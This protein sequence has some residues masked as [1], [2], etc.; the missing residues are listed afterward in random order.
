MIPILAVALALVLTSQT[1]LGQRPRDPVDR[2]DAYVE[3]AMADWGVPGLSIAIVRGDSL[4][5]ARGY[6]VRRTGSPERVDAQ[7][8][9]AIGSNSKAFTT[10]A[11][12]MLAEE[13]KLGWSDPVIRHL[14]WFQLQDPWITRHLDLRDLVSHRTRIARHDALW[15]ATGR[16]TE[17]IVRRLR[18]VGSELPFRT[19]WLYNNNLY[20]TAG[21]VIEK[22]SGMSWSDFVTT[23]I[24]Q[25]LGMRTASTTVRG[26]DGHTNVAS[27]H[28]TLGGVL[29][30]I[31][32]R[33]IDN[34]GP[35]GSINA[36]ALDMSRWLRFQIDSGLVDGKQLLPPRHVSEMW[37]GLAIIN[38]PLF[39]RLFGPGELVEYGLGWFIWL[40]RGHKVVLHGGNIDGMSALVSFIPEKRVGVAILTNMNQSFAHTG[41]TRWV[42]DRLLD[43][44]EED[45]ST[46]TLALFKAAQAAEG[47]REER[48]KKQQV[49]GT[50]PTLPLDRYAGRYADSL[51]GEIHVRVDGGRLVL[52]MDPGHKAD[53]EH[54]N[55]DTFRARFQDAVINEGS[56]FVTFQLDARGEPSR[57]RIE[58]F[59]EYTRSAPAVSSP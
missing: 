23:R 5:A 24:L 3:K 17:D 53:L 58:G 50:S 34:A 48:L 13:R 33:N 49:V 25:P 41:I 35:A 30:A 42:F 37:R 32:Y 26:L 15:Y 44:P 55:F 47:S 1:A 20:L 40:H 12:A 2:L 14:P 38:D 29:Q 6:G 9:F 36:N 22:T 16:S 8:I 19:G 10:A 54:W 46:K 52:D 31:P 11:M 56:N 39:R 7:T 27:P 57:V 45:W 28:M 59:T 18:F 51:Y 43:G 4:L 21:L